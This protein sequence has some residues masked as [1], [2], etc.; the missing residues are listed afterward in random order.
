MALEV[1]E[2]TGCY[3]QLDIANVAGLE[4][5]LREVQFVEWQ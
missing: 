3:G 4:K 2:V 5:L 1:L